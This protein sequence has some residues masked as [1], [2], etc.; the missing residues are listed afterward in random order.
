MDGGRVEVF[1]WV[2]EE[3]GWVRLWWCVGFGG[4]LPLLMCVVFGF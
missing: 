4:G 2:G 1:E 3:A